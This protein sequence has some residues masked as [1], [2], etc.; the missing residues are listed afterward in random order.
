[1]RKGGQQKSYWPCKNKRYTEICICSLPSRFQ[2]LQ[3]DSRQNKRNAIS[4][5]LKDA[6]VCLAYCPDAYNL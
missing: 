6:L 5:F 3:T 2:S 4:A 1:M